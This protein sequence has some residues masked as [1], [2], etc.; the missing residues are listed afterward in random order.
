LV[1]SQPV[2]QAAPVNISQSQTPG[3]GQLGESL[4][5]VGFSTRQN[6]SI[7]EA[8]EL[9]NLMIEFQDI[10]TVK[11][12]RFGQPNKICC[13]MGHLSDL[14]TSRGLL[15]DKQARADRMLEDMKG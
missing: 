6:L 9:E 12:Y 14:P 8:Q 13:Y 1:S 7:R 15:L 2:A 5:T 11:S 4:Q 3:T 10:F